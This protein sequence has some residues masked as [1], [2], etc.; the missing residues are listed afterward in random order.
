MEDFSKIYAVVEE[1]VG[2]NF[3]EPNIPE[4]CV[5]VK[6]SYPNAAC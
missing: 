4:R 3:K 2:Q 1:L 6:L 5:K